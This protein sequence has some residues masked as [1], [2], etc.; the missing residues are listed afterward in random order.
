[1]ANHQVSIRLTSTEQATL[2]DIAPELG[3]PAIIRGLLGCGSPQGRGQPT[4]INSDRSAVTVRIPEPLSEEIDRLAELDDR[5]RSDVARIMLGLPP[6][7]PEKRIV[8]RN[9]MQ[10][11]GRFVIGPGRKPSPPFV[12]R[13]PLTDRLWVPVPARISK[14]TKSLR[15]QLALIRITPRNDEPPTLTITNGRRGDRAASIWLTE[16][17]SA[18]LRDLASA[19]GESLVPFLARAIFGVPKPCSERYEMGEAA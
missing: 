2:R 12:R 1:M 7:A 4:P 9:P 10:I 3:L 5:S 14:V 6:Q 18:R 8:I 19:A 17:E 15:S 16:A 13:A 11:A